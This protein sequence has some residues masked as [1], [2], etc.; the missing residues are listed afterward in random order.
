MCS[1]AP[2][3]YSPSM[4]ALRRAPVRL[5][6][7]CQS[8]R[9][10]SPSGVLTTARPHTLT[11]YSMSHFWDLA[12]ARGSWQYR[13]IGC[14]PSRST[15][16]RT[17][18]A[19]SPI[20]LTRRRWSSGDRPF[21]SS[22]RSCSWDS[23]DVPATCALQLY[24]GWSR[25]S[26]SGQRP[27]LT[28]K[29]MASA[30][31][32]MSMGAPASSSTRRTLPAAEPVWYT[33]SPIR[34]R[35]RSCAFTPLLR[36]AP[37]SIS[38][39]APASSMVPHAMPMAS[40][41]VRWHAPPSKSTDVGGWHGHPPTSC[42]WMTAVSWSQAGRAS[43]SGR[44]VKAGGGWLLPKNNDGVKARSNSC[45][46]AKPDTHINETNRRDPLCALIANLLRWRHG[47]PVATPVD[48]SG[49]VENDE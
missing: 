27:T 21:S 45:I 6:D 35:W 1:A 13:W 28:A 14:M 24:C 48:L 12:V 38:R 23:S 46:Q 40:C 15:S 19:T 37:R 3:R 39:C 47:G 5:S 44:T 34:L 30:A 25:I 16:V 9:M 42:V 11:K 8:G 32:P 26:R 18:G 49:R 4:V 2:Y 41:L 20:F 29:G 17:D 10:P 22:S 33:T 7:A 36:S 31:P 43:G